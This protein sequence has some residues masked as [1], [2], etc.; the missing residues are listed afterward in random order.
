MRTFILFRHG[1]AAPRDAYDDDTK[2]PLTEEGV[3][4]TGRAAEGLATLGRVDRIVTSPYK[5]ARQ[6][7]DLLLKAFKDEP[8]LEEHDALSGGIDY[9]RI[10][11]AMNG[12]QGE[13]LVLVGHEPDMSE[14]T[15]YLLTGHTEMAVDFKKAGACRIA[16]DTDRAA[17]GAGELIY[18]LPPKVLRGLRE[19]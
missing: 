14:L 3:V 19:V 16:F 9:D 18:F 7:A 6:T 8:G 12:R 2:R 15:A 17:P 5:R 10:V 13:T 4:K 11:E 1:I